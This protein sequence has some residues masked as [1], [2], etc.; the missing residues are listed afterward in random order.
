MQENNAY[1]EFIYAP[2]HNELEERFRELRTR[3]TINESFDLCFQELQSLALFW[4]QIT[5]GDYQVSQYLQKQLWSMLV[6]QLTEDLV[7]MA[8]A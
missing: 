6:K 5:S 4:D 3:C 7:E 8:H 2:A 1:Y